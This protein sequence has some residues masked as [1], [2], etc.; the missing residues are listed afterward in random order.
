MKT[1]SEHKETSERLFRA[2]I[3]VFAEKGYE[4]ATV[5]E[6]CK[7][8]EANVAAIN[9]YFGDKETLY[10]QV[11]GEIFRAT[12]ETRS[13]LLPRDADPVDRLRA[14]IRTQF[15]EILPGVHED[16]D[17]EECSAMGTIFMMEVARPTVALDEIVENYIRPE[18]DELEDIL[19]ALMGPD[20][21]D[22]MIG[23]TLASIIAQ[24]LHYYYS[25]PIIERLMPDGGVFRDEP[26]FL[27]YATEFVLQFSLGGIERLTGQSFDKGSDA[28]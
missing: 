11:V 23:S 17:E 1:D 18:C 25:F 22:D 9:Y 24:P 12:N 13:A 16:I 8:A 3:R 19:R 26:G 5:R 21:D 2:A 27:E 15:E 28:S 4:A 20:A 10:R 6:I 14:F 7:R